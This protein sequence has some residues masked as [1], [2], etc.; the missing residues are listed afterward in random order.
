MLASETGH[1]EQPE[2]E[3]LLVQRPGAG[4][5]HRR[6][7]II[8]GPSA[9]QYPYQSYKNEE[10]KMASRISQWLYLA[11]S[12]VLI[13]RPISD[14]GDFASAR[15]LCHGYRNEQIIQRPGLGIRHR[16]SIKSRN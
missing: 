3:E 7:Y 1:Q 9:Q 2:T 13:T 4:I 15:H 14:G 11:V 12:A 8:K 16:R 6:H 10:E 5:G